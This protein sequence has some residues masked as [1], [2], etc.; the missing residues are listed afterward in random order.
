MK[1]ILIIILLLVF[2]Q[3]IKADNN[4]IY[5]NDL[6]LNTISK[7]ITLLPQNTKQFF[8]KDSV[9]VLETIGNRNFK[10]I[11]NPS[12]GALTV[13]IWGGDS[14]QELRL[15]VYNDKGNAL[16]DQTALEGINPID[17]TQNSKGCYT[18]RIVSIKEKK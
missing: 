16:Y 12:K 10:V 14:E 9:A 1:N 4:T 15:I 18:L 11:A 8:S 6:S 5:E 13:E 17:L 7:I 2:S 3:I